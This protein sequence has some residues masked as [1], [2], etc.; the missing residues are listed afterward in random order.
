MRRRAPPAE[1]SDARHQPVWP[2]GRGHHPFVSSRAAKN[3]TRRDSNL[4]PVGRELVTS[5]HHIL[6]WGVGARDRT[7]MRSA[8]NRNLEIVYVDSGWP[9]AFR[10][11]AVRVATRGAHRGRV[12]GGG[13]VA[14]DA[15]LWQSDTRVSDA[16]GCNAMQH[17]RKSSQLAP[18]KNKAKSQ[19]ES[20]V[21]SHRP[22]KKLQLAGEQDRWEM[23][24]KSDGTEPRAA[25]PVP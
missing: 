20:S 18:R 16:T 5:R 4:R 7:K 21:R 15:D 11:P 14:V 12:V 23:C 3:R 19:I 9:G 22:G 24:I 6:Q 10:S 8:A 17:R 13:A 25:G 2:G 1:L